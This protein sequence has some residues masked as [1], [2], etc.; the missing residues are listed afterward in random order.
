MNS[1]LSNGCIVVPTYN[2]RDNIALLLEGIGEVRNERIPLSVLV[3][4]DSSPDG[5]GSLVKE[6]QSQRPWLHLMVRE[7]KT[8]LGAAYKAGMQ[9]AIE[10]LGAE[11]VFEM[12][13]DLSHSPE[14]LKAMIRSL[15]NGADFVIGSR[16]VKGGSLP[17]NWPVQRRFISWFSNTVARTVLGLRVRDCTGGFRAI[18]SDVIDSV[19]LERVDASGYGFQVSLLYRA[20]KLG[21]AIEEVPIHFKDRTKGSSK[22][23]LSD[24]W[25][26]GYLVMTLRFQRVTRETRARRTSKTTEKEGSDEATDAH[27]S[28]ESAWMTVSQ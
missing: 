3:V 2:E 24:L 15:E 17:E 12:D 6:L 22:M 28:D 4:D 13:A 16:Y 20:A 18:R 23:R 7:E 5:T 14:Y 19:G 26:M 25:E 1:H 27:T 21:Y 8:G 10:E 9:H 11:V